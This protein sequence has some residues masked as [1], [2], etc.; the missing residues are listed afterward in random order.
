MAVLEDGADDAHL[1]LFIKVESTLEPGFCG[2]LL[3]AA[4]DIGGAIN[5]VVGGAFALGALL[6]QE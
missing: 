6:C 2:K 4:G 3:G 5:G 1:N